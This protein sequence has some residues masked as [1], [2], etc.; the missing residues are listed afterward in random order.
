M[1]VYSRMYDALGNLLKERNIHHYTNLNYTKNYLYNKDGLL[2]EK[3][4]FKDTFKPT[5]IVLYSYEYY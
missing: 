4:V 2:I 3:Q 5:H 1:G